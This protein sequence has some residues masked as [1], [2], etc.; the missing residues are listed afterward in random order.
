MKLG[1][2][3]KI[4][5][6]A[7]SLTQEELGAKLGLKKQTI[8]KYEKGIVTN[9]PSDKLEQMAEILNVSPAYLMG[10]ETETE[11]PAP[12]E[13]TPPFESTEWLRVGLLGQGVDVDAFT[14]Q[15]LETIASGLGGFV[16]T[17]VD[18]TREGD[19]K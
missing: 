1:E 7:K 5:R 11:P 3:I 19:K 16:K 15:Q 10:W 2:R 4:L 13:A 12:E 17:F 9:I 8:Y 14:P 18:I 6:T